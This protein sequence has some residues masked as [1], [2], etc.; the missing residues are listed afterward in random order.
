MAECC[1]ELDSQADKSRSVSAHV[2]VSGIEISSAGGVSSQASDTVTN[3]LSYTPSQFGIREFMKL[4]I[5]V[6]SH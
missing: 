4:K 6:S 5:P 3:L 2:T 1:I